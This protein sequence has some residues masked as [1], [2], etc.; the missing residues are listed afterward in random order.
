[1][2][3]QP[4]KR[5][6]TGRVALQVMFVAEG[7][8]QNM[9]HFFLETTSSC[10]PNQWIYRMIDDDIEESEKKD[11][12]SRYFGILQ[13]ID[14]WSSNHLLDEYCGSTINPDDIRVCFQK[15]MDQELIDKY[16]ASYKIITPKD[17]ARGTFDDF[18]TWMCGFDDENLLVVQCDD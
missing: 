7:M 18:K 10:L 4:R 12:V 5:T 16:S 1:M 15:F 2:P 8:W 3:D 14:E 6:K 13:A 9:D 17:V 11:A